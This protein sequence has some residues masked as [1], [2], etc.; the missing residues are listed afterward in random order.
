M[1]IDKS[2]FHIQ[3]NINQ[4]VGETRLYTNKNS[5]D[6]I[7]E[8]G[9]Y[10]LSTENEKLYAKAIKNKQSKSLTNKSPLGFTYYVKADP[11]KNLYDPTVLYSVEPKIQK[12]FLNKI[13][14]TELRLLEVSESIFN[15]YITFLKTENAQW[16]VDAQREVK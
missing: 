13:C 7:D 14:K 3:H 8:A 1:K 15:K 4:V 11:N 16:L 2:E 5:Q 10:R 12:S 9:Y 6:Y